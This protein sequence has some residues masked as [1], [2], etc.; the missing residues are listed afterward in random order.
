MR[1]DALVTAPRRRYRGIVFRDRIPLFVFA[2]LGAATIVFACQ[3]DPESNSTSGGFDAAPDS[4]GATDTPRS[5]AGSS[6]AGASDADADAIGADA[7]DLDGSVA[8]AAIPAD[9]TV[10]GVLGDDANPG[11]DALPLKTL[12]AAYARAGDAGAPRRIQVRPGTYA[13]GLLVVPPGVVVVGDEASRGSASGGTVVTG[14]NQRVSAGARLSGFTFTTTN[15]NQAFAVT[16]E[17]GAVTACTFQGG[18][19]VLVA[20]GGVVGSRIQNNVFDT[21]FQ[22]IEGCPSGCD[23]LIE[24]NTF[25]ATVSLPIILYSGSVA[26][27]RSNT[28]VGTGLVGIQA[29]TGSAQILFNTFS[30]PSDSGGALNLGGEHTVR[31]NVI[32]STSQDA[33]VAAGSVDLGTAADAGGNVLGSGAVVGLRANGN[34]Q[35]VGNTWAHAPPTCGVDAILANGASSAVLFADG[36]GCF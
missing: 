9:Y 19:G 5:D 4:D 24:Q 12:G 32:Q 21:H 10:D 15:A 11:T 2:A 6:E 8:D 23:A 16:V 20:G 30:S 29:A 1:G 13:G 3:S 26:V 17:G 31:G 18:A 7:G 27:I 22:G 36:G 33:V 35:A 28:I 14:V 34:V 25:T